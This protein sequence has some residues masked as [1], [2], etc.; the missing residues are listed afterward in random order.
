MRESNRGLRHQDVHKTSPLTPKDQ[1]TD[2]KGVNL[3]RCRM[4]QRACE[5]IREGPALY[6]N[7]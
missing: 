5:Q 3:S 6:G 1:E 4:K 2:L 7:I